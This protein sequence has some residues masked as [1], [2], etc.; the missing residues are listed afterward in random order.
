MKN[1]IIL[2]I[3]LTLLLG[4]SKKNDEVEKTDE[5]DKNDL[6][7]VDHELSLTLE[8]YL[9]EN[10]MNPED[11][12]ISKYKDHDIVIIGEYHR[13]KHDLELIHH[14][15]PMLYEN[16]IYTL[17]IEFA[18]REDQ[19][20][21]DSV[22]SSSTYDENLARQ[23]TFNFMVYIWFIFFIWFI[24]MII[25]MR[26]MIVIMIRFMITYEEKV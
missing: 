15:I 18:K 17:G 11:Y 14:L 26:I 9:N 22:L 25:M 13:I 3:I 20:L 7:T 2:L 6:P 19:F 12:I 5:V 8:E 4:C 21:I 16:G 23:I 10:Y 1:R 24:V